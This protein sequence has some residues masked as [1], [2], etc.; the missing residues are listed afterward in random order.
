VETGAPALRFPADPGWLAVKPIA[1][2]AALISAIRGS[3]KP[4]PAIRMKK[5]HCYYHSQL[6]VLS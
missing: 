5:V 2:A 1:L 4:N 6:A 3:L